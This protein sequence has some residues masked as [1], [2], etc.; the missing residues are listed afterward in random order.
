MSGAWT[1]LDGLRSDASPYD[2][3]LSLSGDPV[4]SAVVISG[5]AS[6]WLW[7]VLNDEDGMFG[8][9]TRLLSRHRWTEKWLVCPWCSGAW[10]A[11]AGSLA[12]YHPSPAEAIVTALAAAGVSGV[13]GSYI[14]GD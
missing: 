14:Q 9:A 4:I 13:V 1:R 12:V 2:P 6:V 8:F 5:L 7:S 3:V 10:F 11:I